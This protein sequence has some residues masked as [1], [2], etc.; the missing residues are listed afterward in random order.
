MLSSDGHHQRAID[1]DR[2]IVLIFREVKS[3]LDFVNEPQLLLGPHR[4]EPGPPPRPT[5]S[6]PSTT[7]ESLSL[8][9]K[10][11]RRNGQIIPYRLR[12]H[13]EPVSYRRDDEAHS[14]SGSVRPAAAPAKWKMFSCP[15]E[16]YS[17]EIRRCGYLGNVFG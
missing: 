9:W 5:V 15:D 2:K 12:N 6:N 4:L 14:I 8:P 17:V 10:L 13:E 7:S 11:L 16:C 1:L 3:S